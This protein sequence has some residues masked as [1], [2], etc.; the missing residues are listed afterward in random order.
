MNRPEGEL[1]VQEIIINTLRALRRGQNPL[2]GMIAAEREI[3]ELERMESLRAGA[4]RV[5]QPA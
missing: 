2:L 5:T 4:K 3:E 1:E